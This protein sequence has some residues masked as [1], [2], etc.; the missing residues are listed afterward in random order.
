VNIPI[1]RY[2]TNIKNVTTVDADTD[3]IGSVDKNLLPP[4]KF[5]EN[6]S[7]DKRLLNETAVEQIQACEHT[8]VQQQFADDS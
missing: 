8:L 1:V 3:P 4:E 7:G 6:P 2:I 5:F